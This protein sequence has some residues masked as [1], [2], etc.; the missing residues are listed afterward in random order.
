MGRLRWSDEELAALRRMVAEGLANAEA[1]RQL[2]RT[3]AA[4]A[5]MLSVLGWRPWR[6]GGGS[7]PR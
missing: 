4:V 7:P 2:G 1:A 5:N 6:F 3:E